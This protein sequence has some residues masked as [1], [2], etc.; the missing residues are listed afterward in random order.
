MR[1]KLK[2]LSFWSF[3]LAILIFAFDYVLFH[4]MTPSGAFTTVFQEEAGKPLVTL[5][6]GIWGVLF[7]F[8]G[9]MS[10]LIAHIFYPAGEKTE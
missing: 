2:T 3:L 4:Y 9:V 1:K 10:L 8:S 6:F 5:L 7:L